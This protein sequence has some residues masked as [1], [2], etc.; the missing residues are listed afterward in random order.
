MYCISC[1]LLASSLHRLAAVVVFAI[2][3]RTFIATKTI[4]NAS[5]TTDNQRTGTTTTTITARKRFPQGSTRS[6]KEYRM[7]S[8][9]MKKTMIER[10]DALLLAATTAARTQLLSDRV[11][12]MLTY[13]VLGHISLFC[14]GRIACHH[15][16]TLGDHTH[17]VSICHL[18]CSD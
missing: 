16:T 18:Y 14:V 8:G 4:P 3:S 1:A 5:G 17:H 11:S 9:T 12:H 15:L 13:A 10:P 2:I 7:V 6:V